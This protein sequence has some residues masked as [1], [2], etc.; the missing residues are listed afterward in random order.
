MNATRL[1]KWLASAATAMLVM[2]SSS[3]A[4]ATLYDDAADGDWSAPATWGVGVGFPSTAADSALINA[5][6]TIDVDVSVTIGS[7]T[8]TGNAVQ[9][10]NATTPNTITTPSFTS[11]NIGNFII[12][13][14]L[15]LDLTGTGLYQTRGGTVNGAIN[16]QNGA[17]LTYTMNQ[18]QNGSG[19]INV[20]PGG[21]IDMQSGSFY[22]QFDGATGLSIDN[23]G[24]FEFN[25][26]GL[27]R[28]QALN[29]T[30]DGQWVVNSGGVS[31][32]NANQTISLN[33]TTATF[34]GSEGTVLFDNVANTTHTLGSFNMSGT[35]T[36]EFGDSALATFEL[37]GP[38]TFHNLTLSAGDVL[39][40]APSG[41]G[42]QTHAVNGTLALLAGTLMAT[43]AGGAV[44]NANDFTHTSSAATVAS[45]LTLNLSGSGT[46]IGNGTMTNDGI[47]NLLDGASFLT[48]G[49]EFYGTGTLH[50]ADGASLT[51]DGSANNNRLIN[52]NI[53]NDGLLSSINNNIRPINGTVSGTGTFLVASGTLDVDN[54]TVAGWTGTGTFGSDATWHVQG[55]GI[56]DLV[57]SNNS[58][59][60]IGANAKVIL[61]DGGTILQLNASARNNL[62][63]EGKLQVS[64]TSNLLFNGGQGIALVGQL[65]GD[66]TITGN[67]NSTGGT[68][69]PG[70]SGGTLTLLGDLLLDDSSQLDFELGGVVEDLLIVSGAL[71]LDGTLNI[72]DLG[73]FGVGTYDLIQYATLTNLALEIGATP[74]GN[75]NYNILTGGGLV[76]LEVTASLSNSIVPEPGSGILLGLGGWIALCLQ[77]SRRRAKYKV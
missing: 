32:N 52:V 42:A 23:D 70:N 73:N 29:V 24:L 62:T 41:G 37:N 16:V 35:N 60:T 51:L 8:V 50:V 34:S 75:Y 38:S 1:T 64:G 4:F 54:T 22:N 48:S 20:L 3:N 57:G 63:V 76:Q 10:L 49:R 61:E 67:V 11:G 69:S 6:R 72:S 77:R 47:I 5:T 71:T 66:G 17:T 36:V 27:F 65:S 25:N 43:D 53:V 55:T 21:K 74:S 31:F 18:A 58:I 28:I 46:W 39:D 7:L 33:P 40:L 15:T 14:G 12:G 59:A 45:G 30:G 44:L 56:I 26:T 9:T 68:I 2:V 13:T 19:S